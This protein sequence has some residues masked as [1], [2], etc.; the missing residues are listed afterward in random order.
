MKSRVLEKNPQCFIAGCKCHLAHLAAGKGGSAYSNV[1]GFDCEEHQVNLYYFFKDSSRWKSILTE[2]LDFTGLEW[3]NFVRY[4][5]T[6]WL[7]L[8]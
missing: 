3:E 7:S 2:F 6:R 1:S 4:V 8:E 5:K